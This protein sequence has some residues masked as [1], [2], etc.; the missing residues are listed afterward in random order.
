MDAAFIPGYNR[1]PMSDSPRLGVSNQSGTVSMVWNDARFHPNGDILLQ[2][3]RLGTLQRVQRRLVGLDQPHGAGFTF[4]PALRVATQSGR[5]D[6]AWY[7]R[8]STGTANTNVT[9]ALGINPTGTGTPRNVTITNK[10]TNWLID[11]SDIVPNFGD[12]IDA[13]V[14]VTGR[15][16]FVGNTLYIAWSD[17]RSGVP[18]PF[19]AH[20]T[21]P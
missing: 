3:F 10:A 7:S 6:V 4:M 5:L 19:A 11:N 16:P 17:G 1:F 12:Y 20:M 15:A 13:V 21:V 14:S 8:A 2:S 9:L 18:Q